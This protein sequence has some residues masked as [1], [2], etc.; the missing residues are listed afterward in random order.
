MHKTIK[1]VLLYM[2]I[3]VACYVIAV[4]FTEG[5]AAFIA[6]FGAGLL[7]GVIADLTFLLHLVRLP[8]ARQR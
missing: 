7:V 2:L 8:W 3:A 1:R 5:R 6:V 4:F